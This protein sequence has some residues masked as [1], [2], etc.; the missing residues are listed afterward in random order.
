MALHFLKGLEVSDKKEGR[1]ERLKN[2][3]EIDKNQLE[4]QLK[5]IEN[6]INNAST[7]AF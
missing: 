4:K 7:K 3:G 2:V 6:N 1:L 5:P